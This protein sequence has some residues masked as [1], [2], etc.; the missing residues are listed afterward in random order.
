MH[1]VFDA[2]LDDPDVEFNKIAVMRVVKYKIEILFIFS[3]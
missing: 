2:G 3:I 1:I